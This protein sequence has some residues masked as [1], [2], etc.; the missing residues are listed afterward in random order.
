MERAFEIAQEGSCK[1]LQSLAVA[2][3][4]EGFTNVDSHL[5]GPSLRKQLGALMRAS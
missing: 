4:K 1:N 3:A 5:E 2:L